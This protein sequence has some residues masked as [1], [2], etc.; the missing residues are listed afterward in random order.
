M[1]GQV[2]FVVG[3]LFDC[4][5]GEARLAAIGS[6][7]HVGSRLSEALQSKALYWL[8]IAAFKHADNLAI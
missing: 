1:I 3:E 2:D 6:A 4:D 7:M 8:R 5:R